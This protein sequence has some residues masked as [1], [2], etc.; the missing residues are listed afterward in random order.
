MVLVPALLSTGLLVYL[1][2]RWLDEGKIARQQHH[3]FELAAHG[4]LLIEQ[5]SVAVSKGSVENPSISGTNAAR[6]RPEKENA[7]VSAA[8]RES[9]LPPKVIKQINKLVMLSGEETHS[10]EQMPSDKGEVDMAQ[11]VWF[12]QHQLC[13]QPDT[14]EKVCLQPLP[15]VLPQNGRKMKAFAVS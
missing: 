13:C 9:D 15:I 6:V 7:A 10:T 14:A 2:M 5:C 4:L 1:N 12:K 11:L 8:A 3:D